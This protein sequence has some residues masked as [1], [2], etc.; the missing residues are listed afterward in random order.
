MSVEELG[1]MYG[2]PPPIH[3]PTNLPPHFVRIR[4]SFSFFSSPPEKWDASI[5]FFHDLNPILLW[6]D[7]LAHSIHT[8]GQS[9][10]NHWLL[11]DLE[12]LLRQQGKR[13]EKKKKKSNKEEQKQKRSGLGNC[14][15]YNCITIGF[16]GQGSILLCS[17]SG[18]HINR[19]TLTQL[20]RLTS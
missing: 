14:Q 11:L 1:C 8:N 17:G 4:Y 19:E 3:P 20:S 13:L 9:S 6:I 15:N 16:W 7:I 18:S 10:L 5:Q 12:C 2:L